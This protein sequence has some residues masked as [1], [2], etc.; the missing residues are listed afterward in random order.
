MSR[1]ARMPLTWPPQPSILL[2][3]KVS[4][5][6]SVNFKLVSGSTPHITINLFSKCIVITAKGNKFLREKD[7]R[8]VNSKMIA[9]NPY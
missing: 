2:L 9:T 8:H 6:I 3:C 4:P 5:G 7:G 1:L